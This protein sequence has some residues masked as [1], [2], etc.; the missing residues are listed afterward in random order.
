MK[1]E[2]KNL[3]Q[4]ERRSNKNCTDTIHANNA[5]LAAQKTNEESRESQEKSAREQARIEQKTMYN[6]KRMEHLQEHD[7]LLHQALAR[8]RTASDD[9]RLNA[10]NDERSNVQTTDAENIE[11]KTGCRSELRLVF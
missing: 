2:K 7:N 3:K 4:A 5:T 8:R 1:T 9:G 11:S 10:Q 6:I